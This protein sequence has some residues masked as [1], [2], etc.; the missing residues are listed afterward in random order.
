[1]FPIVLAAPAP[2]CSARLRPIDRI[3][4]VEY[5]LLPGLKVAHL[6]SK[7]ALI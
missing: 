6:N 5:G 3:L 2:R 1:M 4:H 7:T